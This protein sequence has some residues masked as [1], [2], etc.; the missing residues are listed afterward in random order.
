[1]IKVIMNYYK[2]RLYFDVLNYKSSFNILYVFI[3]NKE[4][5]YFCIHNNPLYKC[6]NPTYLDNITFKFVKNRPSDT[7]LV[8]DGE[9][10]IA[11][12]EYIEFY[13]EDEEDALYFKL[14]YC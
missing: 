7:S 8:S 11:E 10:G 4:L 5:E 9:N 14:K 13:F 6:E 12:D 1:M 3:K 2:M